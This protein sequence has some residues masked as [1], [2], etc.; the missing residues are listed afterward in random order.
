MQSSLSDK[1]VA[2]RLIDLLVNQGIRTFFGIPGGP[3]CAVFEAIRLNPDA[4]LIVV[5]HEASAGLM[6]TEYYRQSGSIPCIVLSPGPGM[7]NS[8]TGIANLYLERC[9]ALVLAGDV[10][11]Q[12]S[13]RILAQ[14]AG[15]QGIDVMNLMASV[16][17][18]RDRLV[19]PN[20]ALG[21]TRRVIQMSCEGRR[22]PSLLVIPLDVSYAVCDDSDL[23]INHH[24]YQ[25]TSLRVDF[26]RKKEIVDL[27][28]DA[29]HPLIVVGHGARND[30]KIIVEIAENFGIPF[31]TTPR[32]KFVMDERHPLSLRNGGIAASLWAREYT[33]KEVD[34]CLVLGT[35]LDD[36]SVGM[37]KYV[38]QSTKLIHVDLNA[39][40]FGRNFQTYRALQCSISEFYDNFIWQF[41][42]KNAKEPPKILSM[43]RQKSPFDN[44]NFNEDVSFRIR[45][46]RLIADV[47]TTLN[48]N[49]LVFSDIGEHMLF[50]LHYLTSTGRNEFY[51]QLE[52]GSMGSGICAAIGAALAKPELDVVCITGDGCMRM[53]GSEVLTTLANGLNITFVV[54]ND[55]RYNMVHHG[56]KQ[57][58]GDADEY[59]SPNVDFY[60]WSNAHGVAGGMVTKPGEY[61][62]VLNDLKSCRVRNGKVGPAVID[63]RIDPSVKIRGGGRVEALQKMSLSRKDI[64]ESLI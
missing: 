12:S 62:C 45:P 23:N 8:I 38:G 52:L 2:R 49:S 11:W 22:G 34:V 5:Q 41:L 51:I 15:H 9:P 40:V 42:P 37:T 56:M 35:D 33:S 17:V 60:A 53:Y 54:F 1:T 29:T 31:V 3:V 59:S 58:F 18:F 19:S 6:A 4:R 57:L 24:A 20:G 10:S 30:A 63:A 26:S 25:R 7:T 50:C 39:S 13:G 27:L 47:S 46:D 21:K 48:N 64:E 16:T 32:A 36:T 43:I 14:D 61:Q 55:G 44:P 28:T